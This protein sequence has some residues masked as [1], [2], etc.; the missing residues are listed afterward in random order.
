MQFSITKP[1]I[2]D[3]PTICQDVGGV[4]LKVAREFSREK[5]PLFINVST[6]GIPSKGKH[7]DVPMLFT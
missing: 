7:W 4:I 1:I 5:K 2:L 3:Q 6:T